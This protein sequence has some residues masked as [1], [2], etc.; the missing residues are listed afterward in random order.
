MPGSDIKFPIFNGNWLEDLEQHWFM[1]EAVWIVQQVQD[2]AI[3]RAQMITTFRG[4][5]LD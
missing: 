5:A 4:H 1:C 3:K 2:E